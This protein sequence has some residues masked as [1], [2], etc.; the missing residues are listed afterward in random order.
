ME[1][2]LEF[3]QYYA[4]RVD[5]QR[6]AQLYP[7]ELLNLLW[8]FEPPEPRGNPVREVL[9]EALDHLA[10]P[11]CG[12]ALERSIDPAMS[13]D[14][15]NRRIQYLATVITGVAHCENMVPALL[16][17]LNTPREG[18]GEMG[19][20]TAQ[21]LG[22]IGGPLLGLLE[23]ATREMPHGP[24]FF[25]NASALAAIQSAARVSGIQ[26]LF[27]R[28]PAAALG[29]TREDPERFYIHPWRMLGLQDESF[30]DKYTVSA[31]VEEIGRCDPSKLPCYVPA[32]FPYNPSS[33]ATA[34]WELH[35]R[36]AVLT[37]LCL[38]ALGEESINRLTNMA[39]SKFEFN[40]AE[41]VLIEAPSWA[42]ER[43]ASAAR[44]ELERRQKG[45]RS[46]SA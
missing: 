1:P 5:W 37:L 15:W 21:A 20:V 16:H 36:M 41:P 17:Q 30:L 46:D 42:G 12:D 13:G 10:A 7:V 44:I 31:V 4:A 8:W 33:T 26:T 9:V 25:G 45:Q 40:S 19:I 39:L 43:I 3:L 18:Q 27:S 14:D 35:N 22:E 6:Q 2:T 28:I 11:V 29:R 38:H 32:V 24:P 34:V 23:H